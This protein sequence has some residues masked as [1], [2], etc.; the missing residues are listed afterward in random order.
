M[1]TFYVYV[2]WIPEAASP[3][4]H[5]LRS[6]CHWMGDVISRIRLHQVERTEAVGEYT[7]IGGDDAS[8][9]AMNLLNNISK[10]IET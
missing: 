4:P 8:Y 2:R 10:R 1:P 9:D 3:S 5:T 6:A 7:H